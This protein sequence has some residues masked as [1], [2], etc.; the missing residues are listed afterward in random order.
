MSQHVP[1]H[2]AR[3]LVAEADPAYGRFVRG[4]LAECFAPGTPEVVHA[5]TL[6]EAADAVRIAPP[7]VI[8]LDPSLPGCG[9]MDGVRALRAQAP[10]AA[11]VLL[12]EPGDEAAA[13]EMLAAGAQDYLVRGEVTAATL[14]RSIGGALARSRAE[15]AL[16]AS[17]RRYRGLVQGLHDGVFLCDHENRVL[18]ATDRFLEMTG[19]GADEIAGMR[20]AELVDPEDLAGAPLRRE[21]LGRTGM[22]VSE[23]VLRRRDG[24]PLPV[25][26]ASVLLGDG[27]VECVVRD[28]RERKRDDREKGLLAEAG[29]VFASS[30]DEG[31]MLRALAELLVP[32]HADVCMLDVLGDDGLPV[33]AA[34]RAAD[35]RHEQQLRALLERYPHT[36][37]PDRHPVGRVLQTGEALLL[38]RLSDADLQA[39]AHDQAYLALV[40]ELPLPGSSMVVPLVARGRIRGALTLTAARSAIPFDARDLELAAELARRAALAVEKA[41]LNERL[42]AAVRARDQVLSYVAHD[43]RSPLG[44]IS[45]MAE[46]LLR[47]PVEEAERRRSLDAI[48]QAAGQMDRLIQDLLDVGRIEGGGLRLDAEPLAV[49][50]LVGEAMLVLEPS[51]AGAGVRLSMDLPADLPPVLADRGRLLQVLANLVENAIRFTPRGGGI[52]LRA[53]ASATEVTFAVA[54]TG[55]GIAPEDLPRLFDRF[56]QAQRAGR[57]GAGL[58]LAIARGIVEA[59]GGRIWA[60]SQPGQGSTFFFTLPHAGAG[61]AAPVPAIAPHPGPVPAEGADAVPPPPSAVADAPPVRVLLV[62]DHPVV[63]R[64]LRE[65]LATQGRYTVVGEAA[66]GPD[67]VGKARELAPDVVVMDLGMPGGGGIAAIAQITAHDPGVKVLAFTA[68]SADECL[69]DVLQAGGSGL[70]RKSTAHRDLVTALEAVANG[71]LFLDGHGTQALARE[72]RAGLHRAPEDPFAPLTAAERQVALLTAQGFTSREIGKRVFLAPKTVDAYRAQLM[73]KL[74]LEHRAQLV[75]LAVRAGLLRAE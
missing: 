53:V 42:A 20:V 8:L 49:G 10:R 34:V 15:A 59:H 57:G 55:A 45:L 29:Q 37:G 71:R 6:A 16:A 74:G 56:W 1:S 9:G 67:A 75:R 24:Q 62:D 35:P 22:L 31:E 72:V 19:Y 28:I 39:L 3:I 38:P 64:G 46:L 61:A 4:L 51:A 33:T 12:V 30:L 5:S 25:E 52:T 18:E 26:V 50:A 7:D 68:E 13:M 40:R 32:A 23:R 60:E 63:R 43:L 27:R 70:V 14:A 41:R 54:D 36:A 58:G 44:G 48:V 11:L 17:E 65:L 73:R 21:A 66:S 2:P 69:V 47:H